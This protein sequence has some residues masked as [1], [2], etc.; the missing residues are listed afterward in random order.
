MLSVDRARDRAKADRR[1]G[2]APAAAPS[3]MQKLQDTLNAFLI[4]NGKA[5]TTLVAKESD[6]TAVKIQKLL[7][8]MMGGSAVAAP[9]WTSC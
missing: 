8:S 6:S 7:V 3:Q 9:L 4:K 5:A 2:G 1:A